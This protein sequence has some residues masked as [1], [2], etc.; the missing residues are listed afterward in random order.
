MPLDYMYIIV[1]YMCDHVPLSLSIDGVQGPPGKN[2][3]WEADVGGELSQETGRHT[4]DTGE[5]TERE[6]QERARH[7]DWDS[8]PETGERDS[9]F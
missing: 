6:P 9:S 4:D 1:Q 2:E 7:G 5:R 3:N 8:Y